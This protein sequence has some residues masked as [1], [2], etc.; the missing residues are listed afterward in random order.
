MRALRDSDDEMVALLQK[1]ASN[2]SGMGPTATPEDGDGDSR[3]FVVAETSHE[4]HAENDGAVTVS[5]GETVT[6]ASYT[7]VGTADLLAF[8][9]TDH[10]DSEYE[11]VVDYDS[12]FTT[13]SP[14]GLLNEPF[15]LQKELG[16]TY[17]AT[18][19]VEYRVKRDSA[20][21]E[22]ARYAARLFVSERRAE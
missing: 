7:A 15:S 20:V 1:I 8:G 16:Y 6:L 10:A 13:R 22:D 5:P 12:R 17:P 11:L 4:S 19:E 3:P 2:T 9:A 21:A 18:K 14:L